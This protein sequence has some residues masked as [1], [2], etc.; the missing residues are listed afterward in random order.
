MED[1]NDLVQYKVVLFLNNLGSPAK[2]RIENLGLSKEDQVAI[3]KRQRT[4]Y[5]EIFSKLQGSEPCRRLIS[6]S[7]AVR[8]SR[9]CLPQ[10]QPGYGQVSAVWESP[11][12]ESL[13]N[14]FSAVLAL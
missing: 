11:P 7:I 8:T 3:E 14:I 2:T 4:A 12:P 13:K 6:T 9:L 5:Q 10:L 1:I